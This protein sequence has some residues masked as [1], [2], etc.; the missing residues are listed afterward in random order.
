MKKLLLLLAFS[1]PLLAQDVYDTP[2]EVDK[3][4]I[5]DYG[6]SFRT[7]YQKF[8]TELMQEGIYDYFPEMEN[9]IPKK[10]FW[11]HK[12]F[13]RIEAY[14]QEN[15]KHFVVSDV[16]FLHEA[17]DLK[18]KGAILIRINKKTNL[19]DDH[20]SENQTQEL[21]DSM[22]DY[23]IDNNFSIQYLKLQIDTILKDL[24]DIEDM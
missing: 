4:K 7:L 13:K 19:Q 1:L 9:K 23:K 12:L 20:I 24:F 3:E 17:N 6:V 11:I 22:I 21:P 18:E 14:Q 8:G 2:E 15:H 10:M 5:T 16:R